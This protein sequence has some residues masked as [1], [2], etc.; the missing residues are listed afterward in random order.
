MERGRERKR[1]RE[2]ERVPL[3]HGPRLAL[4][5]K[6]LRNKK[7]RDNNSVARWVHAA[8]EEL[9]RLEGR[10]NYPSGWKWPATLVSFS[11]IDSSY[12]MYIYI[13]ISIY[14]SFFLAWF[15]IWSEEK[16]GGCWGG[17]RCPLRSH[18]STA[19]DSRYILGRSILPSDVFFFLGC[20]QPLF[21]IYHPVLSTMW[22]LLEAHRNSAYLYT[23]T[24]YIGS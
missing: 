10:R 11:R 13:Y 2:R 8:D 18:H 21:R 19:A 3:A 15:Y 23:Y 4:T 20:H 17:R 14:F 9:L 22:P 7:K 24:V 1:E 5:N 16:W 12:S 6:T